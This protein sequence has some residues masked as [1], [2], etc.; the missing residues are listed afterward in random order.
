MHLEFRIGRNRKEV[1]RKVFDC[2]RLGII[3]SFKITLSPIFFFLLLFY[4]SC[5]PGVPLPIV[6]DPS[7]IGS[8]MRGLLQRDKYREIGD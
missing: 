7:V 2:R 8:F 3:C 5:K 4:F 6:I 1:F